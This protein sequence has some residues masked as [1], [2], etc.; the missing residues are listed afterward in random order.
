MRILLLAGLILAVSQVQAEQ[1]LLGFDTEQAA[2][3]LQLEANFDELLSPADQD[4]WLRELS[5]EPHHV[6]SAAG[7]V[8]AQTVSRWLTSWG[9]DT[10]IETYQILLP[11]PRVRKLDLIEPELFS[12]ELREDSLVEDP[13]TAVRDGLLPPYNAFSADGT[14]EGEL[15][16]INYGRPEDH[17][18]LER[19]GISLKGKVAIAK[20]GKSWRGIK[21]KLAAEKGAVA[22]II[23]S[24][25]A[26]DGYGSG[27]VYPVGPY[28]H[29]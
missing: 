14:A 19:Y 11:T 9:Y 1:S 26:D 21:P 4:A 13:S 25:P 20:Y 29:A 16:F 18:L 3:Q 7:Q 28:K 12:A 15:V 2:S 27:D 23:Y 22:T 17:E 10:S 24:D 8:V 6:G 5:A